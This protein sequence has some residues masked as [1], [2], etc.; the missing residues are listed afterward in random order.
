[1]NKVCFF[2]F[3]TAFVLGSA[4]GKMEAQAHCDGVELW[5]VGLSRAH[6]MMSR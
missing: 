5:M 4:M 1:M 3:F 6:V 2:F